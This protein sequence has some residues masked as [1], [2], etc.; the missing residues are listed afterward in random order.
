[1]QNNISGNNNVVGTNFN[2]ENTNKQ[3]KNCQSPYYKAARPPDR[4]TDRQTE[5][6]RQRERENKSV[7]NPENNR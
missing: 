6:D 4:Q 2:D 7:E 3:N 5:S 1:M